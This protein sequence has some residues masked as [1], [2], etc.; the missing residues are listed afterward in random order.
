MS[1]RLTKNQPDRASERNEN[2]DELPNT[3]RGRSTWNR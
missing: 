1:E 3:L 2:G